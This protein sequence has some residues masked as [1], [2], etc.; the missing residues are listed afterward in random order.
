[1]SDIFYTWCQIYTDNNNASEIKDRLQEL[2]DENWSKLKENGC[3]ITVRRDDDYFI[4][5]TNNCGN[6][7]EYV[8]R[9]IL[10]DLANEMNINAEFE[11]KVARVNTDMRYEPEHETWNIS[12]NNMQLN[13]F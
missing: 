4:T 10:T 8:L 3:D 2:I 6:F 11:L 13:R 12:S 1:M 9:D 7:D 5:L